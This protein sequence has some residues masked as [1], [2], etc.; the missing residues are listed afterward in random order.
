MDAAWVQTKM[1][2][3]FFYFVIFT[4]NNTAS[5]LVAVNIIIKVTTVFQE[6]R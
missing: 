2:A 5:T 1:V 6:E 4:L 3:I